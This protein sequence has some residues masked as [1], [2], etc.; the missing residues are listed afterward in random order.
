MNSSDL[1]FFGKGLII[2]FSIAA[3]VGPIAALCIRRTLVNGKLSGFLSGLGAATAD[4]FYGAIAAFGLTAITSFLLGY[5][6]WIRFVGGI[7]LLYLG[8]KIIL[9]KAADLNKEKVHNSLA[10]DFLS[11]VFLTLTNPMTILAFM[12]VFAGIG[13]SASNGNFSSATLM[14]L[15]VFSGS[16]LWWLVLS[17]IT[18]L[19]G[20]KMNILSFRIV[21]YFSGI[22]IIVFGVLAIIGVF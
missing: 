21:N 4:S 16:S 11:T 13:L 2:G 22:V 9:T 18:V 8:I 7:F 3:P 15:G 5:Q 14:V 20:Q 1:W 19:L 6:F 10:S 12:A 17:F